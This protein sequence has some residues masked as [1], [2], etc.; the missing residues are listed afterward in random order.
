[1]A[2]TLRELLTTKIFHATTSSMDTRVGVAIRNDLL[3]MF[4]RYLKDDKD[5]LAFKVSDEQLGNVLE[6]LSSD[7]II[8]QYNVQQVGTHTF[9]VSQRALEL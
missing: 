6:A 9:H 5:I 7:F 8:D 2:S 3:T 4:E 1:M